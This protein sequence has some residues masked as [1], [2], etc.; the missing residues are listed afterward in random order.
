MVRLTAT[1][2]CLFTALI[3]TA[4]GPP[5][6]RYWEL[7]ASRTTQDFQRDHRVCYLDAHHV[8]VGFF[9]PSELDRNY[10]ECL[11]AL[12]WKPAEP[13]APSTCHSVYSENRPNCESNTK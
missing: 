8:T 5:A 4:C 7:P 12:G 11:E 13:G 10:V 9:G 6:Y 1:V 3:S 2:A